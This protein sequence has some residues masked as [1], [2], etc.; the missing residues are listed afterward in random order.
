MPT[1]L[2]RQLGKF[3]LPVWRWLLETDLPSRAAPVIAMPLLVAVALVARGQ[4]AVR[5]LARRRPRL[6]WGPVPVISLK[7]WSEALGRR[8]Y[9]SHTCVYG[10]MVINTRQDF[11]I[12]RALTWRWPR[13]GIQSEWYF[14]FA[15]AL[16]RADIFLCFFE[17]SF[18][19]SSRLQRLEGPLLKLAGKHLVV[20]P[21]GGD[22]AV[23][24]HL[25]AAEERLLQDYP[26][27]I[28]EGPQI[29]ERVDYYCD[30]ADVVVRNYQYGY[31]PRADVIW[32][33]ELAIDTDLWPEV[34]PAG[35]DGRDEPVR[36]IHA[37]N[38]RRI[39]ATDVLI[40]AVEELR[41]E[42]LQIELDLL[43]RRPNEEIR[44][45]MLRADIVA[46]QFVAGYAMFAI[47]GMSTGKPV[48]SAISAIPP[49]VLDTEAMR[50]CPIVDADLAS[51]KSS[52]RHMVEH[53][54]ERKLIGRAGRE[55]A[56]AYHSL[57]A[58]GR[59][60]ERIFDHLWRGKPLPDQ[61]PTGA[62]LDSAAGPPS[63][64]AQA[65]LPR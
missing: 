51:L 59:A 36:V 33:T 53:P 7:Y 26:Q 43:E 32:P 22:I 45:A 2:R 37:P 62:D 54:E 16:L 55:F 35:G 50:Q 52:L 25:G 3:V 58:V 29:K 44:E 60:W 61:L 14:A 39:K 30:W 21:Y 56:L 47:E 18:L 40:R 8:G 19:Y 27:F 49:D 31:M 63:V 17:G 1:R 64:E 46:D 38:H 9:D 13:V 65:G 15:R 20:S 6:I 11:D 12:V 42:G 48:L 34:P 23:P 41:A 57:D 10:V 28:E 24:G 5:R 4:T